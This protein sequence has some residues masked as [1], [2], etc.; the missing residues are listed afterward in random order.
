MR[1]A[2]FRD[3]DLSGATFV[4]AMMVGVSIS[5]LVAGLTVNGV[6]VW[7]LIE[8][9][10]DR[11]HPERVALRPDDAEGVRMAVQALETLWAPTIEFAA[12]L[13]PAL[14]DERV[15]GEWSFIET[16]RHLVFVHDGW[17]LHAALGEEH[18]YHPLGLV[19]PFLD[20][21]KDALGLL[22]DPHPGLDEVLAVRAGR[23]ARL[24][25]YAATA[26]DADLAAPRPPTAAGYPP[27]TDDS[28]LQCLR[29]V[30]DEEWWHHRYATR[31][32]T[33]LTGRDAP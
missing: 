22:P 3:V 7:P 30:F 16:L 10:L 2:R 27:A 21:Q 12:G 29:G 26:T 24:A 9:E 11:L 28:V 1:G 15:D 25:E 20:D 5:G 18:P 32:L 17:F 33:T 6:E 4:D 23:M 8:A 19:P 14:L 31:D 13:E